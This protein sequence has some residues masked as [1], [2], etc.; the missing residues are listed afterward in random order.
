M[1]NEEIRALD[2]ELEQSRSAF[3]RAREIQRHLRS[4]TRYVDRLRARFSQPDST[5][6]LV[7]NRTL[8]VNELVANEIQPDPSIT[9]DVNHTYNVNRPEAQSRLNLKT[10]DVT[11]PAA[12]SQPNLNTLDVDPYPREAVPHAPG[13][14]QAS[15][16]TPKGLPDKHAPLTPISRLLEEADQGV[17]DALEGIAAPGSPTPERVIIATPRVA[18]V[19][20]ESALGSRNAL[21]SSTTEL[22][23]F[24]AQD[25]MMRED[26]SPSPATLPSQEIVQLLPPPFKNTM[27]GGLAGHDLAVAEPGGREFS[28]ASKEASET[29]KSMQRSR[30][31]EYIA[32]LKEINYTPADGLPHTTSPPPLTPSL[33]ERDSPLLP[34][35]N[36]PMGSGLADHEPAVA[37]N[38]G[39]EFNRASE[40]ALRKATSTHASPSTTYTPEMV[41][42]QMSHPPATPLSQ[43]RVQPLPPPSKHPIGGGLV[44][45]ELVVAGN[46]G[47]EL[48]VVNKDASKPLTPSQKKRIKQKASKAKRDA[49]DSQKSGVHTRLTEDAVDQSSVSGVS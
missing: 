49:E 4:N 38:G 8:D 36:N 41:T 44:D 40:D 10:L 18:D 5:I 48:S 13:A 3:L 6:T 26:D 20:N 19:M 37:G 2:R 22:N 39:S 12:Q 43:E 9:H 24:L 29:R 35:P 23:I 1:S 25:R 47:S 14:A 28:D 21:P 32:C 11:R 34:S 15:E 31:L 42:R 46:G 16:H 7:V 27:G 45:H 33:Q 17:R 30:W